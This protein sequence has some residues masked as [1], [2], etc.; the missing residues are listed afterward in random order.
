MAYIYAM[1]D[2]HGDMDA[3]ERALSVVD[4]SDSDSRLVFCGD[5]MAPPGTDTTMVRYIMKFQNDNPGQVV[6]LMGNHELMYLEDHTDTASDDDPVTAWLRELPYY[7]ETNE[8]I[9]VHAGVDEEAGEFWRYGSEDA[10]FCEKFP[11]STG[12]FLKDVVAGHVGTSTIAGDPRFH[13]V[14]WDG[15]SHFYLDGSVHVSHQI[16]VLKYD[17][18]SKRYT[19]YRLDADGAPEEHEP[20]L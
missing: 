20:M 7:W 11:W 4:L 2:M 14:Y 9:F 12:A 5:Y 19:C 1:S 16:P 3:F 17:T 15:Q 6:A 10:Y 18:V 13:D 8:Q